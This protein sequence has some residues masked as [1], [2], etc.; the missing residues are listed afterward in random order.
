MEDAPSC[1]FCYEAQLAVTNPLFTPCACRGSVAYVHVQCLR[2]W[3]A[4]TI[5]PDFVATCE[6]CKQ[7]FSLPLRW[8]INRIQTP[9]FWGFFSN[10]PLIIA[11]AYYLHFCIMMANPHM[12]VNVCYWYVC[13]GF[14]ALYGLLYTFTLMYQ[15]QEKRIYITYWVRSDIRTG[16]YTPLSLLCYTAITF[17][18]LPM[19]YYPM[20]P[21]FLYL[22]PM[23]NT[24]HACIMQK[25]N[26]DAEIYPLTS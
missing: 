22:L 21:L 16:N 24:V 25:M 3:R 1:R 10:S 2:K 7:A 18:C 8:S 11:I 5:N 26:T 13:C 6:V 15:L 23:Y 20:G 17:V 9:P 4:T 12:S 14:A 19:C